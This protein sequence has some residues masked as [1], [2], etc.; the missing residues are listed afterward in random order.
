MCASSSWPPIKD[1]SALLDMYELDTA[2][3][4]TSSTTPTTPTTPISDAS[5]ILD[6]YEL[7][8]SYSATTGTA[9]GC[10]STE[11]GS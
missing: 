4:S 10:R 11:R 3:N 2:L 5:A 7:V 1:A 6:M 8:A 9:C